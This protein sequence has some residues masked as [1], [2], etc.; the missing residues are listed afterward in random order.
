[1]SQGAV[2][3]YVH[4]ALKDGLG[5]IGVLVALESDAC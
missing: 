5:K 1:M 3:S 2:V 4:G